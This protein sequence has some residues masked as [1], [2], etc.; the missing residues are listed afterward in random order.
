MVSS[1]PVSG[2]INSVVDDP[3]DV[4]EALR[5]RYSHGEVE[6]VD[7]LS[8]SFDNYRFNVR[9]SNTEPL[10]RLNVESRGDRELL[11]RRTEEL[12]TIIK[13]HT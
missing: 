12:L 3:D 1:F 2:E 8:V 4:I 5:Q 11:K 6:L 10:L 7:G 9:K 13:Q